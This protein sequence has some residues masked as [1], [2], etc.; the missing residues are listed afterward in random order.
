MARTVKCD[1]LGVE[2]EGLAGAGAVLGLHHPVRAHQVP[3]AL[4]DLAG[5]D[6]LA[7]VR[8]ALAGALVVF[9]VAPTAIMF[10]Y[11]FGDRDEIG[12]VT[13][14]YS[15]ED[16]NK[17]LDNYRRIFIPELAKTVLVDISAKGM[18]HIKKNGAFA[19]LKKAGVIK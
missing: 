5:L 14:D 2:A 11:S 10:V 4:V 1:V 9:V 7:P 8:L 15:R 12:R 17:P 16:A 3:G 19:T 18:R 6:V 13:F